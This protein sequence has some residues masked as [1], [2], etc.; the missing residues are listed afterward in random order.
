MFSPKI[1]LLI[2]FLFTAAVCLSQTSGP[3]NELYAFEE[4]EN[5]PLA[6][7]CKA[8]WKQKKQQECTFKSV[9]RHF[10]KKFNPGLASGLGIEGMV[11]MKI[12]FV[13]DEQGKVTEVS[14]IGGPEKLNKHGK[15]VANTLPNFEPAVH[16]GKPVRVKMEMPLSFIVQN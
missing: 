16:Q 15:E 7:G 14:A 1:A 2:F 12:S 5:P 8:K 6:Q 3:E 13:I 4:V 10:L 9:Q 11:K